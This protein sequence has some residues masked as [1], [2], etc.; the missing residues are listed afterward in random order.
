M[1][2]FG[3]GLTES[4]WKVIFQS[5]QK[6]LAEQK[7]KA[8]L[9]SQSEIQPQAIISTCEE[10]SKSPP[11]LFL[12]TPQGFH[13]FTDCLFFLSQL[14]M[15]IGGK[16][17]QYGLILENLESDLHPFIIYHPQVTLV[18]K[19][20]FIVSDPSLLLKQAIQRFPRIRI[21]PSAMRLEYQGL[22]NSMENQ[23]LEEIPVNRLIALNRIQAIY[24][25][26][27]PQSVE[28]WL[29]DF[30]RQQGK[31]PILSQ[32]KGILKE[33]QGCYLFPGI[34]VDRIKTMSLGDIQLHF[35]L[36]Y[37]QLSKRSVAFKR[38]IQDLKNHL[39]SPP[40]PSCVSE[41]LS[42]TIRCLGKVEII[43][44]FTEFFLSQQKL[45]SVRF[46]NHLPPG[47]HTLEDSLVWL[48]LSRFEDVVLEGTFLDLHEGVQKILQP[49]AFFMDVQHLKILPHFS[50]EPIS[51][52]EMEAQRDHL[53]K[54]EKQLANE[55]QQAHNKS[56]LFSQEEGVL[57]E[58]TQIA[59][60]LIQYLAQS[61]L[62]EDVMSR[63]NVLAEPQVLFF[64][65]EQEQAYELNQQMAYISK[66]LW[67][68]PNDYQDADQLGHLNIEM[69]EQY[70]QNG[71]IVI[72]S[73]ST[74]HW[75]ALNNQIFERYQEVT[76]ESVLQKQV[77]E[78]AQLELALI[79]QKK[80]ALALRWI[81]TSLEHLLNKS[82][83][84]L[85][86][87]VRSLQKKQSS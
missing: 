37:Q 55:S 72:T 27:G 10:I 71:L 29:P 19:M 45:T 7:V 48:R 18:N 81:Y 53:L 83:A 38:M 62:W 3:L 76:K 25:E 31:L 15:R 63:K 64:C 69:I 8:R 9:L 74:K 16:Q 58:A 44:Q 13:A 78:Q 32:I 12:L 33:K 24:T 4:H 66:K 42:I 35:I 60:R 73:E 20:R 41:P 28:S 1:L 85:L 86:Q 47:T 14:Q 68:N 80:E 17:T 49:L 67:I 51:R 84:K 46:I 36:S 87:K 26:K 22:N 52:I 79:Q 39:P 40:P 75:E 70:A 77:M 6:P 82:Q 34:P 30:L 65:E 23:S 56:L 2:I 21:D 59:Q 61:L 5:I 50:K 57:K 11:A 54:Q 43:N